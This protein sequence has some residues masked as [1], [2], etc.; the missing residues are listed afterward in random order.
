MPENGSFR[1]PNLMLWRPKVGMDLVIEF[2]DHNTE[3]NTERILPD[4]YNSW[5]GPTQ[6][7]YLETLRP[8]MEA[9]LL[10]QYTD[11]PPTSAAA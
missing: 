9:D 5:D 1:W 6:D 11:N 4:D 7:D 2:E 10:Q 3:Y 8:N